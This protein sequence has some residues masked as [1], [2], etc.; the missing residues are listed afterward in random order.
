MGSSFSR[1]PPRPGLP[2]HRGKRANEAIYERGSVKRGGAD[3]VI[4]SSRTSPVAVGFGRSGPSRPAGGRS[5]CASR[6]HPL[7]LRSREFPPS[8]D[9]VRC[10]GR[11]DVIRSTIYS[12]SPDRSDVAISP[13]SKG[14][15]QSKRRQSVLRP[16]SGFVSGSSAGRHAHRAYAR[17]VA[18]S[19]GFALR[20]SAAWGPGSVRSR[21]AGRY[22]LI[23]W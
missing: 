2:E 17:R 16:L 20:G 4:G 23:T 7:S 5:G 6:S 9:T 3:F 10:A 13:T 15:R 1:R 8:T 19:L 11:R 14:R 21:S 18:R 12:G 22:G